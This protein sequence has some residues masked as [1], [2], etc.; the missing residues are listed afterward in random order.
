MNKTR[1]AR[2]MIQHLTLAQN[3]PPTFAMEALDSIYA[4]K[5]LGEVEDFLRYGKSFRSYERSRRR[6]VRDTDENL[7]RVLRP[8]FLLT[9]EAQQVGAR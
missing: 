3:I 2:A 4:A 5:R 7:Y 6:H 9:S 1:D 8:P